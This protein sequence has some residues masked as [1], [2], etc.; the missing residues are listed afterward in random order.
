[1]KGLSYSLGEKGRAYPTVY[2]EKGMLI[3]IKIFME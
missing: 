3:Y 1:L 2:G